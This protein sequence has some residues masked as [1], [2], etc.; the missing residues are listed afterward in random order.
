MFKHLLYI[1]NNTDTDQQSLAGA[2]L[3][4][5]GMNARITLVAFAPKIPDSLKGYEQDF[6]QAL[7]SRTEETLNAAKASANTS[8]DVPTEVQVVHAKQVAAWVAEAVTEAHI[9]LVVKEKNL[10][11]PLFDFLST[12][13]AL[14]RKT[15]CALLF[16]RPDRPIRS[17]PRR[18]TLALAVDGLQSDE[19]IRTSMATHLTRIGHGLA[20]A[21]QSRLTLLSCYSD[22]MLN[23]LNAFSHGSIHQDD[24]DRWHSQAL[25]IQA[26][27]LNK[28]AQSAG[29]DN[30]E[31][32]QVR[33]S[34]D[35]A[36]MNFVSHKPIDLLVI[37]AV[38]QSVL[39]NLLI[40]STAEELLRT[41]PAHLL[42]IKG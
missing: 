31:I 15:P 20:N 36:I 27:T 37:G 26:E 1:L 8:H 29:V 17:L 3:L 6:H 2:L 41:P 33:G 30:P 38:A 18:L 13:M 11:N 12:D 16:L 10:Q 32:A 40:G 23:M 4:A 24:Q 22:A 7:A 42:L 34:P 35:E 5:A 39:S 9:D 14:A 25:N 21:F 19:D 28:V